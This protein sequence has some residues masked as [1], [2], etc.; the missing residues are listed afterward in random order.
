MLRQVPLV[1][2]FCL[3]LGSFSSD[4]LLI[5]MLRQH[6]VQPFILH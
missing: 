5:G 6:S 2:Y 3:Q 1:W 4:F